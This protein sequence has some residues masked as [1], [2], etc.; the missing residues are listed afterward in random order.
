[1]YKIHNDQGSIQDTKGRVF[2]PSAKNRDGRKYLKWLEVP[3][4]EPLPWDGPQ[5]LLPNPLIAEVEKAETVPE[6]KSIMLKM[7]GATE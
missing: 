5:E 4:N 6:L 2:P 3:E 1:M 7:L